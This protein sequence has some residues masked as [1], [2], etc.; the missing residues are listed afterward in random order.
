VP[1][2][3]TSNLGDLVRSV[4]IHPQMHVQPGGKILLD[5]IEKSQKLLMPVPAAS[6]AT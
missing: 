2:Q 4:I 1:R 5:F 3:P 6:V